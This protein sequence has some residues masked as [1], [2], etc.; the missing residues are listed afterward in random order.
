MQG[1]QVL[2][3]AVREILSPLYQL[4]AV[5]AFLYFFYGVVL[6][7]DHMNDPEKINDGK[8]HLLW[9]TI[10]LFIILSVGGILQATNDI[11]GGMFSF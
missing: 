7:I 10:G 8:R 6:F 1:E 11:I 5:C 9:G 4:A 3:N 2:E